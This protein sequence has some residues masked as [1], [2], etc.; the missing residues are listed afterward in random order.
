LESGNYTVTVGDGQQ[1]DV[2]VPS[3][4]SGS[5]LPVVINFHGLGSDGTQQAAL[6]SYLVIAELE[7]FI[8]AHPT[9]EPGAGDTRN[10]W[11]LAQFDVP[12]RDDVALASEM[13]DTLILDFCGDPTRVYS[14]GM[15]NGGL[16]TSYLVCELSDR[17]AAA[18]SVAG[19]TH[20]DECD[21][22]RPVP[23]MAFHGTAD[24][25]VP[26]AGGVSSLPGGDSAFFQQVMPEEF[27]EFAGDFNCDADPARSDVSASVIRYEYSGCD[28]NVPM[29]FFEIINGGHT[30]PG[31]PF[32]LFMTEILGETTYD[33]DATVG[34]WEF[35]SRF[36]LEG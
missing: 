15:S 31:S 26:F 36:T 23:M 2:L 14:T 21:P 11:E 1:M 30:W 18:V 22:A 34:G 9:G 12:G 4:F 35:M 19:V 10:S 13:I 8:V 5:G 7:G 27:A 25:I 24:E 16:F 29:V 28:N 17:I 20:H 3:N 33:V 32:G 6:S